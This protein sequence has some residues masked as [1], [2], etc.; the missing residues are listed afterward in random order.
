MLEEAAKLTGDR[1]FGL[2][3][4]EGI[5]PKMFDL[6]G[7]MGMN[8]HTVGDAFKR[9]VRYL[10]IWTDGA[11]YGLTVSGRVARFTYEYL[12]PSVSSCRQDC[13]MTL[14]LTTI[15]T[16]AMVSGA[17]SPQ[18][19]WFQHHKPRRT[20]EHERI[21][22]VPVRFGM[23]ANALIFDRASL[24]IPIRQADATLCALLDRY[25][26]ELLSKIPARG[27][28]VDHV[29]ASVRASISAGE[30]HL[31]AV[32]KRLGVSS[33]TLQRKLK[34]AGT[35][36]EELLIDIRRQ[37]SCA[38]L[39]DPAIAVS[40][41]AYLLSFSDPSAF[42]RAFRAWTGMTPREYRRRVASAALSQSE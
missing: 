22:R 31:E 32:A 27:N 20:S 3:L 42:H 2:H 21:F 10:P 12:D 11:A 17:W 24:K 13:E 34:E 35:S 30:P 1:D 7:Y 16:R 39:Q 26:E 18:E 38:Y 40:E 14:A 5:E 28:F 4:G 25:A 36:H 9:N 37:L 23:P 29:R 8:S 15:R 19:V 6:L 33:R 41:V